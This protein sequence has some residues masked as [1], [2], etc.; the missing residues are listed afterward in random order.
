MLKPLLDRSQASVLSSTQVAIL[1]RE[2]LQVRAELASEP[3]YPEGVERP[4][5]RMPG[6]EGREGRGSVMRSSHSLRSVRCQLVSA[7]PSV[8][9]AGLVGE[10]VTPSA[11]RALP[12]SSA[13]KQAAVDDAR[14]HARP[15]A[16]S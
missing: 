15:N 4:V 12:L 11:S 5:R 13:A 14:A 3:R 10:A 6:R 9:V 7:T 8:L 16:V 2:R 1:L